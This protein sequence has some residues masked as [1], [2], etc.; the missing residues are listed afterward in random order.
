MPLASG[1][2]KLPEPESICVGNCPLWAARFADLAQRLER[3]IVQFAAV[4]S[5]N[6]V[7]F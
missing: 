4:A 6:R 3:G 5:T 2:V 7:N 1:M